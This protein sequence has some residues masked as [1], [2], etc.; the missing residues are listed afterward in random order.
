MKRKFTL[1]V[2]SMVAF[3]LLL[4]SGQAVSASAEDAINYRQSVYGVTGWNFKRMGAMMEGEIDY[5]AQE[6]LRM[7]R[8]VASMSEIAPE[9]FIPDS[10]SMFGPTRAKDEIW[11]KRDEFDE[12]MVNWQ[13][14]AAELAR[15]AEEG[16]LRD[17]RNAFRATAN[18]CRACHDD[19]REQL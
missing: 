10:D 16:S 5:D 19:F 12:K 4:A 14:A 18:S 11:T 3:G 9:G 2:T 1:A 17:I 8:L 6:F 13:N 7:A 15:I